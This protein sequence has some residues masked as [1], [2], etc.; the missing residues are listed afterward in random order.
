M[1]IGPIIT[2]V[3]A[4]FFTKDD[5]FSFLKFTSIIIG[6]LGVLFIIDFKTFFDINSGSLIGLLAKICVIIAAL[7]YMSSNII[8]YNKLENINAITIT[9]FA[10]FFGALASLPFMFFYEYIKL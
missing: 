8:A 6:F 10:T 7:G 3:L 2:L 4:H 1:S 5:K 9:T